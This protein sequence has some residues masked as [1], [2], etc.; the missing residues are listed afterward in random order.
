MAVD[1]TLGGNHG[2]GL[3]DV[4]LDQSVKTVVNLV[5]GLQSQVFQR[6]GD[7]KSLGIGGKLL[8]S[9]GNMCAGRLAVRGRR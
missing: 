4:G 6:L 3:A 8:D 2:L 9:L 7:R 5:E 1:T